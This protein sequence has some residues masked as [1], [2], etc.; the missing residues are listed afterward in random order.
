M[1]AWRTLDSQLVYRS[2]VLEVKRCIKSHP[3]RKAPHEFVLLHSSDWVNLV[4][5]TPQ[6]KM[7]LIRQYRQ[8]SGRVTLEIPGGL[9]DPG[10]RP[11]E[12]AARELLEETGYQAES[13]RFLGRVNPNPALFDNTCHTFLA[14]G[15]RR[16]AEQSLDETEDIEVLEMEP[17]RVADLVRTGELDHSLVVAAL[18]F[19]WLERG[20]LAR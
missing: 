9:V 11:E 3:Q 13:L 16:V 14:T 6:E 5:L 8:G 19:F 18:C 15:A 1:H 20:S 10:E 2:P 17:D 4:A 7:V 12:A